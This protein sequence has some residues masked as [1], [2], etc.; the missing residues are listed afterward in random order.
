MPT[1]DLNADIGESFGP[2]VMGQ[3]ELLL[4]TLTSANVACGFH[5]GDPRTMERTVARCRE[6]GVAIGAH[7]GFP[8]LVGF[9]RRAIEMSRAE[10]RT[11]VLYQL[12]A[13]DAFVRAAGGRLEHVSPHG[14]LGNLTVTDEVYAG[15][16]LDAVAA[17]DDQLVVL[18][19]PGVVHDLAE[20][21]G[22]RS[23]RLG[24][25]DRGYE[26]DG[27]LVSRREPDALVHDPALVAERAV[28]MVT[29]GAVTS[30]DGHR[31][32]VGVDAILLHGDSPGAVEAARLVRRALED[33]GVTIAARGR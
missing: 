31:V 22:L 4:P 20:R 3:D 5:A 7:P 6:A 23:G 19:Q 12:G 18:G 8:D 24:F 29:D 26:A 33:A 17:F 14:R 30:R 28:A 16:V 9:G 21:R 1:I 32:E 10:V 15:G 27:A 11:D 13:L 25:P 2:H